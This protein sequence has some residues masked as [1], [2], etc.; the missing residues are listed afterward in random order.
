MISTSTIS[1]VLRITHDEV[2]VRLITLIIQS[3]SLR[4]N[5][6]QGYPIPAALISPLGLVRS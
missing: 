5:P 4:E 2:L 6:S 3:R 1:T